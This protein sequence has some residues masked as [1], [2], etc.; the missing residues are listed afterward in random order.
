[1][2]KKKTEEVIIRIKVADYELEVT[3]PKEWAEKQIQKFVARIR[4]QNKAK[5]A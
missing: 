4:R 5:T 3:G 1:M 2:A